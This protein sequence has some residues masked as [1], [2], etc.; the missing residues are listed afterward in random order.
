RPEATEPEIEEAARA[1]AI[2][3]F[4]ASLPE[5]Y[6]TVVGERGLALSAGE[7]QR[8][9]IARAFLR[10]PKV[11]VLDEPTAALDAAAEQAISDALLRLGRG[12]P[13]IVISHRPSLAEIPA[14][15]L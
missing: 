2:H 4:I 13:V 6:D 9:A 3:E 7:R 1:A 15:A 12:R 8:V 5:G 10:R 11:L 14:P